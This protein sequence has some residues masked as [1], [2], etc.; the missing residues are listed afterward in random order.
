MQ[1]RR[2]EAELFFRGGRGYI[3][4]TNKD[5]AL[6]MTELIQSAE[7]EETKQHRENIVARFTKYQVFPI[8]ILTKPAP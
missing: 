7:S 4:I 8:D 6:Q 5:I 3:N 1:S 2:D